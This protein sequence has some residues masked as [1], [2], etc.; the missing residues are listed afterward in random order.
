[1]AQVDRNAARIVARHPG[2]KKAVRAKA[3]QLGGRARGLLGVHRAT[4]ATRIEVSSGKVDSFV[5]M[6]GEGAI[7]IE[8][9]HGA[10]QRDGRTIGASQG[11]YVIHRAAG[12]R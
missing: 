5:S 10:Y 7:S 9:G 6:V 8:Y 11:L 12:M 4:G 2:V 3:E 1:M